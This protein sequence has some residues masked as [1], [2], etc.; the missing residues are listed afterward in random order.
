[1]TTI[2]CVLRTTKLRSSSGGNLSARSFE[3]LD[4]VR[5]FELDRFYSDTIAELPPSGDG[6]SMSPRLATV[7]NVRE[8]R[9]AI[10]G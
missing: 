1:M 8:L 6:G 4:R 7:V 5:V 9:D 2:W 10:A 3:S